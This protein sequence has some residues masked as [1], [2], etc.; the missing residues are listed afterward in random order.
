MLY[1]CLSF[2]IGLILA[3]LL[4]P[5]FNT[6]ASK[7]LTMPRGDWW[8][9]PVILVSAFVV[10]II[11]GL[12]PAFYLS[13]F[14]PIQVLKGTLSTGSKGSI[15]RNSL[16]VFQFTASILLIIGTTVIYNQVHYILNQKVGFDKD[17]VVILQGTNT[18][19]NNNIK[20]FKNELS[21]LAS[22]KASPSATSCLL[23]AL[24]VTVFHF[25]STAGQS[26]M[27]VYRADLGNRRYLPE[28]AGYEIG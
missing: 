12:Y 3:W 18:L 10:G 8:L 14:K 9:L 25:L 20:S 22:V 1:S 2:I 11:A 6:L 13:G 21:K 5:Y 28:N 24:T 4:L 17:Q 27:R 16:V 19:D 26:W 23:Q 15:L 7:S